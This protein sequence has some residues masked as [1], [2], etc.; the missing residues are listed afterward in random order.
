MVSTKG[1]IISERNYGVLNFPKNS[2][3][4]VRM[5]ASKMGQINKIYAHYNAKLISEFI[6][7]M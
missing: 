3:I 1:Q 6:A 4:I 7:F 2:E 5:S